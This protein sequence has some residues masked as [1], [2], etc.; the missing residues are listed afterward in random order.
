MMQ[1]CLKNATSFQITKKNHIL[2]EL[3]EFEGNDLDILM[4]FE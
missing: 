2:S 3:E 1:F 4:A